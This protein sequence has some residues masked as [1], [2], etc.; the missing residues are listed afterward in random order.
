M[1][2]FFSQVEIKVKVLKGIP[3]ECDN[4]QYLLKWSANYITFLSTR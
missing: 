1:F 4:S 2:T 3:F